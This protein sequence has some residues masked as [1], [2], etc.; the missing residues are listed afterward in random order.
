MTWKRVAKGV[1]Y[2]TYSYGGGKANCLLVEVGDRELL[3][4]SPSSGGDLDGVADKGEVVAL[5]PP[6]S[7]HHLGVPA[8]QARFPNA[9]IYMSGAVAKRV[10]K[11]HPELERVRPFEDLAATLPGHVRVEYT[12]PAHTRQPDTVACIGGETPVF[13]SNDLVGNIPKLPPGLPGLAFKLAGAKTGLSV[14]VPVRR[15]LVKKRP[16]LRRWMQ[17]RIA[18]TEPR[19]FVP[20]H[21]LA[22]EADDVAERLHDALDARM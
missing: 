22:I 6:N 13:Y 18:T 19:A 15:L 5:V 20:G 11:K 12:E 16:A 8:W 17:E 7:F 14:L 21:G 2:E 10:R 9:A 4:I 3:A 1:W